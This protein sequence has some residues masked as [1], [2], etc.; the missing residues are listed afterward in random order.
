MLASDDPYEFIR[1][2]AMYYMGRVGRNDLAPYMV[3]AYLE[4]YLAKRIAFNMSFSAHHLNVELLKHFFKD[5]VM[6]DNELSLTK[7]NSGRMLK[8]TINSDERT[9]TSAGD[10]L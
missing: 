7:R 5:A 4:D 1:R 10:V 6:N 3:N 8:N 9:L 2:K